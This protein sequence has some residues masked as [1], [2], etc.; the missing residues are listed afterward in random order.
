MILIQP[1]CHQLHNEV[2]PRPLPVLYLSQGRDDLGRP[3]LARALAIQVGSCAACLAC[4]MV[5]GMHTAT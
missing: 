2:A 1:G 4:C 3:L 5:D